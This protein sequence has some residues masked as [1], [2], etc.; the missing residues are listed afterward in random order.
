MKAEVNAKQSNTQTNIDIKIYN[1]SHSNI[2]E[3]QIIQIHRQRKD[4]HSI[5]SAHLFSP[6]V[7]RS[8]FVL[9]PHINLNKERNKRARCLRVDALTINAAPPSS[10]L[11]EKGRCR[12]HQAQHLEVVWITRKKIVSP[13]NKGIDSHL[14]DSEQKH[15]AG[16]LQQTSASSVHRPQS[17]GVNTHM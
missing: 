2:Q 1:N 10:P 3:K 14:I 12:D 7:S 17:N 8:C 15:R 5:I 16:A 13:H 6:F 4:T 11:T 9:T